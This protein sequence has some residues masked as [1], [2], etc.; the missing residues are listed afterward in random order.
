MSFYLCKNSTNI[1]FF[2][3]FRASNNGY[4]SLTLNWLIASSILCFGISLPVCSLYVYKTSAFG[5]NIK[6]PPSIS[7]SPIII[8]IIIQNYII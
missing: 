6:I 4:N 3:N 5:D 8:F 1:N 2:E 7:P